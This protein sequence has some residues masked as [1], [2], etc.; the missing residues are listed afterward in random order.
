MTRIR[1]L[2]MFWSTI[3]EI[4]YAMQY[5]INETCFN[6]DAPAIV[7]EPYGRSYMRALRDLQ[8][9]HTDDIYDY[10]R[11]DYSVDLADFLHKAFIYSGNIKLAPYVNKMDEIL[12]D[13]LV[14]HLQSD[15][16]KNYIYNVYFENIMLSPIMMDRYR[17]CRFDK[18]TGWSNL[19]EKLF[20]FESCET[21]S[22]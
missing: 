21:D 18:L 1:D 11:A 15:G 19:C 16:H 22:M 10:I 8:N 20:E 12:E 6:T 9:N 13:I 4:F 14:V 5:S 7:G 2:S 17:E 3:H